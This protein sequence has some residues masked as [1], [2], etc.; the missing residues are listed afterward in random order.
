MALANGELSWIACSQRS[1]VIDHF[2]NGCSPDC[3]IDQHYQDDIDQMAQR[4][5]IAS[6]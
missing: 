3:V 1:L 4:E 2:E 6:K 5:V